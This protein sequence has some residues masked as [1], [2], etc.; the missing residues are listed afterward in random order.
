MTSR[1]ER[2]CAACGQFLPPQSKMTLATVLSEEADRR[3]WTGPV[4]ADGTVSVDLCLSCQITRTSQA[5]KN[6]ARTSS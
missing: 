1:E 3:G 2:R 4:K 5:A 6:A